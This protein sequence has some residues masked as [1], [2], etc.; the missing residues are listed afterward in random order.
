MS[1]EQTCT[2][3]CAWTEQ[4]GDDFVPCQNQCSLAAG[5]DGGHHCAD[6]GSIA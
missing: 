6:H 3:Q 1:D 2:E 4:Q 5:H